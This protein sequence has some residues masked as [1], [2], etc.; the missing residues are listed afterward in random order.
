MLRVMEIASA[1]GCL[2]PVHP[3]CFRPKKAKGLGDG[4]L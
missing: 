3:V 2:Y 1:L 4:G